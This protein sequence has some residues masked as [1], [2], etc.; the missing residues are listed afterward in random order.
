MF[1]KG[2]DQGMVEASKYA[3]SIADKAEKVEREIT[4]VEALNSILNEYDDLDITVT[5]KGTKTRTN[6]EVT[7]N[8]NNQEKEHF[9]DVIKVAI[10]SRTSAIEWFHEKFIRIHQILQGKD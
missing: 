5:I 10:N 7:L 3:T 2:K 6:T 9:K 4:R 1:N 8:L